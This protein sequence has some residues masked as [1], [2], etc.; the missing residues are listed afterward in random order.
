[1][2]FC[3]A[4][5]DPINQFAVVCYIPDPLGGFITRL[6]EE[7]VNGCTAQSHVTILPPRPLSVLPAIAEAD[8]RARSA[9]F[10]SFSIDIPRL[11]I[12]SETSV[13]FADIGVG[14]EELFEMHEALNAGSLAFDE[15][16]VYHPHITLA[17]GLDA[18]TV[19]EV[20]DFAVRRWKEEQL[21]R[22]VVIENLTFVRNTSNN[23]WIDLAQ[24]ELRG[25]LARLF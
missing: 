12:F 19:G 13:I 18:V 1:M 21:Q 24:C 17:Q 15:P 8:L 2:R 23:Q 16:H 14:R 7:L 5:A 11:R 9:G 22:P 3:P 6:R 25:A 20:Y 10:A 4:P